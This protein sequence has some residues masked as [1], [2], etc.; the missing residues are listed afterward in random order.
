MKTKLT[1]LFTIL[2]FFYNAQSIEQKFDYYQ[3]FDS[4]RAKYGTPMQIALKTTINPQEKFITFQD[5]K[6]NVLKFTITDLHP[7]T[8]RISYNTINNNGVKCTIVFY[9][10]ATKHIMEIKY[11]KN[12]KYK[13]ITEY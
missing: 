11:S 2:Y 10:E 3:E 12:F 8:G 13:L 9:T 6:E 5:R 4:L 7:E 1:F